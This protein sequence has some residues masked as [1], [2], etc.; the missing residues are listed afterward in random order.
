MYRSN[1][2]YISCCKET[3]KL[4]LFVDSCLRVPEGNRLVNS[5]EFKE[6]NDDV[7]GG[8]K[9]KTPTRLSRD[10]AECAFAT[11][12]GY[13]LQRKNRALQRPVDG[14]SFFFRAAKDNE[15]EDDGI[16]EEE[17]LSI[18]KDSALRDNKI[19]AS[20]TTQ[21]CS[22]RIPEIPYSIESS[23]SLT[24]GSTA[25][26]NNNSNFPLTRSLNATWSLY[27][28][29]AGL[30]GFITIE[31]IRNI[32]KP[33]SLYEGLLNEAFIDSKLFKVFKNR[34]LPSASPTAYEDESG[35]VF[36]K[37]MTFPEFSVAKHLFRRLDAEGN[38]RIGFGTFKGHIAS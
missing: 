13:K 18:M 38:G 17:F 35:D 4:F 14:T 27:Q 33:K 37:E 28:A 16:T 12:T 36:T 26:D 32:E 19:V 22:L 5:M 23:H 25:R 15:K 2:E 7:N 10:A 6:D 3:F 31:D 1:S 9:L 29:L 24:R 21:C 20:E 11:L 30:N 34:K 8:G